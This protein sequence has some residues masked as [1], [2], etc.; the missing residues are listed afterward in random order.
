MRNQLLATVALTVL[1]GACAADPGS[2][3]ARMEAYEESQEA[4]MEAV[5]EAVDNLPDWF[6]EPPQSNDA[7]YSVG[8]GKSNSLDMAMTKATLSAKRHLAD[9]VAGVLTE[10]IREFATEIG[11]VDNP[12]TIEELERATANI[13]H[14][15]PV[16]GYRISKKEI[17][18]VLGG[19]YQVY[20]LLEYGDVEIN[21]VLKRQLERE[22]NATVDQRKKQLYE[23]LEKELDRA[24]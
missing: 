9:R 2:P 18:P 3:E 13:I 23:D 10:K 17:Q 19:M 5:E 6:V 8:S 20:V 16:Y 11:S 15:V 7:V 1:L 12:V 4:K 24:I 14:K 22:R 21:K